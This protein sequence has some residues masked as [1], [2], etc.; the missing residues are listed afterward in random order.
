MT[1]IAS[2]SFEL[3][4]NNETLTIRATVE[5]RTVKIQD[6]FYQTV[7]QRVHQPLQFLGQHNTPE[8]AIAFHLVQ[9]TKL[10]LDNRKTWN[11]QTYPIRKR[12]QRMASAFQSAGLSAREA[13]NALKGFGNALTDIGGVVYTPP[14]R[15]GAPTHWA[16]PGTEWYTVAGE[17]YI[18]IDGEEHWELVG[19][20]NE[21]YI[22]LDSINLGPTSID[23]DEEPKEPEP[24]KSPRRKLILD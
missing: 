4:S 16:P 21:D 14:D 19:A 7:I 11:E 24:G 6:C 5:I 12:Q 20:N 8:E 23:T 1:A 2:N 9:E 13:Y 18:N 3:I 22:P 10:H 17:L 15:P